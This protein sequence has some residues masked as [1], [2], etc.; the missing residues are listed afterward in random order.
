MKQNFGN[1]VCM[2]YMSICTNEVGEEDIDGFKTASGFFKS[3]HQSLVG[4]F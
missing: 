1:V 2:M 3:E 4:N